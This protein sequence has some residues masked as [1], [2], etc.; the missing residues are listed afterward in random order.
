M[1]QVGKRTIGSENSGKYYLGTDHSITTLNYVIGPY[2][3]SAKFE[4]KIYKEI[5]WIPFEHM[6]IF[7]LNLLHL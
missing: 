4:F 1:Q 2:A 5:H 3:K 6:F 7:A